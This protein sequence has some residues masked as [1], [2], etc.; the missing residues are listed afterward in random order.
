M[1]TGAAACDAGRDSWPYAYDGQ[2]TVEGGNIVVLS[3]KE[4]RSWSEA[5]D[6]SD[7]WPSREVALRTAK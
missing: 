2:A 3:T 5:G 6:I 4:S 1:K 7:V